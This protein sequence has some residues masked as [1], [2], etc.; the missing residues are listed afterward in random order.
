MSVKTE[1]PPWLCEE[2]WGWGG[3]WVRERYRER[4]REREKGR[5]KRDTDKRAQREKIIQEK[6][7]W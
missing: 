7:W 1:E 2:G 4:G 6:H 5:E 3:E